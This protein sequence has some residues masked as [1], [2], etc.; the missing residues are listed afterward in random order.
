MKGDTKSYT[1][2]VFLRKKSVEEHAEESPIQD[3][4]ETIVI[5]PDADKAQESTEKETKE[6][7]DE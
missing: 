6:I 7:E 2:K 5:S 4:P 3:E 1:Q